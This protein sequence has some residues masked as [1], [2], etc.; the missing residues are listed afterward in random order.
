[1]LPADHP[2]RLLT[3]L[4]NL[5]NIYS[6]TGKEQEIIAFLANYLR[7]A[8][9]PVK[10]QKVD[11]K[12]KN[13]LVI[14]PGTEMIA[15]LVGHV[16]TVGA[17]ELDQFGCREEDDRI[18]GLGAADMKGGCAALVEAYAALWKERRRCPPAA[19]ALVCGEEEEG[20]GTKRLVREYRFPWALIAEPTDMRPCFSHFGYI[21]LHITTRGRRVHASLA[22]PVQSPV[23]AMLRLLLEI[24]GYFPGKRP[25]LVYNIRDLS[26]SQSGFA[27]PERS[28][29]WIDV[30]LPPTARLGEI[31]IELEDIVSAANQDNPEVRS[32]IS[33]MNVHSGYEL[34]EKGKFAQQLREAYSGERLAWEPQAFRS[35]SDANLLWA[36]G[37]KPV[38]LGPGVLER[39]HSPDESVS[40]EQVLLS[41]RVYYKL[42]AALF[43]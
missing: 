24:S 28:D 40:F 2:E 11:G 38:I 41:S 25:D 22:N 33:F 14:P 37:T 15:V 27:V 26:S 20:D 21:E 29:V 5:I 31:M 36:A 12:R 10:L 6:P 8:G 34:P 4:R 18:I 32:S 16:D 13:L 35:H 17:Y 3:L 1:M 30:H 39:A 42:L 9:L 43:N 23:E 7:E 19:L